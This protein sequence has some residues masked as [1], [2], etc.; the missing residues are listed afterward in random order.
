MAR[1]STPCPPSCKGRLRGERSA[2]FLGRTD[3]YQAGAAALPARFA[4]AADRAAPSAGA[5]R[6]GGAP[7]PPAWPSAG[8][9]WRDRPALAPALPARAARRHRP[10]RRPFRR[11]REPRPSVGVRPASPRHRLPAGPRKAE[12][13]RR[14][15]RREGSDAMAA[16][17]LEAFDRTLQT[18]HIWLDEIMAELGP[19]RQ[20]A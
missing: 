17:G 16:T 1:L 9:E 14:E 18:T 11:R 10:D 12:P 6:P 20:A 5:R 4:V 3:P 2:R 19:D 7:I 15:I 8:K 13:I